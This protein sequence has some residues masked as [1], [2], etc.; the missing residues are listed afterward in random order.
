M[1][2]PPIVSP[3]GAVTVSNASPYQ[4]SYSLAL[5]HAANS[6]ALETIVHANLAG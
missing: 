3:S 2:G 5:D 6:T 1:A 4:G